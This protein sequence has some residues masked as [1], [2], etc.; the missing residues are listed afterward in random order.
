M[1]IYEELEKERIKLYTKYKKHMAG[2]LLFLLLCYGFFGIVVFSSF[3]TYDSSDIYGSNSSTYDA[4]FYTVLYFGF[5]FITIISALIIKA[6]DGKI[7]FKKVEFEKNIK[8]RIIEN[9]LI[10]VFEQ[11]AYYNAYQHIPINLINDI[12]LFKNPDKFEGEGL[13]SGSYEKINFQVSQITLMI[14]RTT[15]NRKKSSNYYNPY[16]EGKM[17]SSNNRKKSSSHW[18]YIPYFKGK[19]YAFQLPKRFSETIKIIE[20]KPDFSLE[21]LKKFETEMIEFNDKFSVYATSEKFFYYLINPIFI[22]KILKFKKNA[23]RKNLF[24]HY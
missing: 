20:E 9:I 19:W 8:N 1:K 24:L 23:L 6:V 3:N 10:D 2:R 22:E 12:N 14:M 5:L 4:S 16:F 11:K 21:K 13:I 15:S 18:P 17:R 7:E